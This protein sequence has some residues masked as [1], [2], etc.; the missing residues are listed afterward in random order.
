MKDKYDH[1]V[2]NYSSVSHYSLNFFSFPHQLDKTTIPKKWHY[3]L[4]SQAY[5]ILFFTYSGYLIT[6]LYAY[7]KQDS[8]QIAFYSILLSLL[9]ILVNSGK[10]I[11]MEQAVDTFETRCIILFNLINFS[12]RFFLIEDKAMLIMN[13]GIIAVMSKTTAHA[14]GSPFWAM[15]PIIVM[16]G[17][18]VV[19][20]IYRIIVVLFFMENNTLQYGLQNGINNVNY[21][22]QYGLQS[23]VL[24]NGVL[25]NCLQ[26]C[27]QN[28][29]L[30][31]SDLILDIIF[32]YT[33]HVFC[34][35]T[36][37]L[38]IV[39]GQIQLSSEC[40]TL[41]CTS[42]RLQN[43]L[44]AKNHFVS[45]I[46]HEFRCP[47]L[48]S[49]GSI[50]LIKETNLTKEQLEH[51]DTIESA[52]SIL[53]SLIEDILLFVKTEH[54]STKRNLLN[55]SLNGNNNY[56]VIG[57]IDGNERTSENGGNKI[58]GPGNFSGN[59]VED[60][61]DKHTFN[62][63]KCL[64]TIYGIIK[65]Y[66][67]KFKVTIELKLDK[68]INENLFI[69]TNQA[70]LQQAI[71]NLMTN[72]VKASK[73]NGI[74]ELHC[75]PI[76]NPHYTLNNN[77]NNTTLNNNLNNNHSIN[78]N[79][80]WFEFCIIDY[81][82][83]IP[84][85]KQEAI[86]QPFT[87]L[88]NLNES[89]FPGSGLGL[90]TVLHIVKSM[91]GSIELDSEEG[92]G[93]KFKIIVPIEVIIQNNNI[94][95]STSPNT[96]NGNAAITTT[97]NGN[98]DGVMNDDVSILIGNSIKRQIQIQGNYLD[99]F[100]KAQQEEKSL[101]NNLTN[102]NCNNCKNLTNNNLNNNTNNTTNNNLNDINNN[103]NCN[104]SINDNLIKIIIAEDN[105]INRKVLTKM[106]KSLGYEVDAVCDGKQLVEKFNPKIHKLIITDQHMPNMTGINAATEIR[107]L[108]NNNKDIKIILLT[109]DALTNAGKYLMVVDVIINKPCTRQDLKMNIERLLNSSNDGCCE[110][111]ENK[112]IVG[113]EVKVKQ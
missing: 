86:F 49:L 64:N 95:T 15:L 73:P 23:D 102:N 42:V 44:E 84:K 50:E 96:I 71:V 17:H 99:Q 56:N 76:N 79:V 97:L 34:I 111:K 87:Q 21:T 83:G 37:G 12:L 8:L 61:L 29:N 46:S 107:N 10:L 31:K 109:A 81:G 106:L 14:R 33:P 75:K 57:G 35:V 9:M 89:I 98:N 77:T 92:K 72:A 54:E 63:F 27:L 51:V 25:Q 53:L 66:A 104:N 30:Q 70:R 13:L 28:N 105:A 67:T 32:E 48:S 108:Y 94:T 93:S 20:A 85:S 5:L 26:N 40:D 82:V 68:D 60:N 59:V 90:C 110:E 58:S 1:L 18:Y 69:N 80:N 4:K 3:L 36:F 6:T 19:Y 16:S 41:Q 78:G 22:L 38:F 100:K 47:I 7:F 2:E 113:E 11:R 101:N 43:A 112:T 62:L 91:N 24:Q 88:H 45:H 39:F 52:N 103:C 74:V 65:S 55:S